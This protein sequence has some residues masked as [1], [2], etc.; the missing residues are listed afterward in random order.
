MAR[1]VGFDAKA[2]D[3]RIGR[4]A[5]TDVDVLLHI[6]A[7]ERRA[8][9]RRPV[10][11]KV[12]ARIVNVSITGLGLLVDAT[13][14]LH[15]GDVIEVEYQGLRNG[16]RVTRTSDSDDPA[17]AS[18]GVQFLDEKPSLMPVLERVLA[19]DTPALRDM[20]AAAANAPTAHP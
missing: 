11:L 7:V 10:Q 8:L 9:R 4:R 13:V 17:L 6:L 2:L 16:V 19:Q 20:R 1:F 15:R 5:A 18:Y 12:S 14:V 3:Q